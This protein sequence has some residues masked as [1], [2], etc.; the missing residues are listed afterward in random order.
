MAHVIQEEIRK[1][2]KGSMGSSCDDTFSS[3]GLRSDYKKPLFLRGRVVQ[4]LS[5]FRKD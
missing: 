2:V 1:T 5:S 4:T 3:P